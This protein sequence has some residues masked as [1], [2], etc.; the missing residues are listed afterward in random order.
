MTSQPEKLFRDKLENFQKPAP[1]LAWD[2]IEANLEGSQPKGLWLKIA[3]GLLLVSVATFLLWPS[4]QTNDAEVLTKASD[5]VVKPKESTPQITVPQQT[6]VLTAEQNVPEKKIKQ[7]E[8][9]EIKE[10]APVLVAK[11]VLPHENSEWIETGVPAE[12]IPAETKP[13]EVLASTTLMYSA[14]EVNARFMK[15]ELPVQATPEEKKSSGIQKLMGLAYDLKHT[16]SGIGDLRQ[17]KNE[18]L[19]LNFKEDKRGQNK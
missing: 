17:K 3:A 5:P 12:V 4:S 13:E 6:P 19:A 11:V 2:R 15:K 14:Q 1:P 16:E 7:K 10:D 9:K 8:T 18:I